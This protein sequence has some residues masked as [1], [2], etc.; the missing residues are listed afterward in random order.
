MSAAPRRSRVMIRGAV[1]GVG[2][3]AWVEYTALLRGLE[4]WVRNQ[5]D[6]SVEAVF[7]GSREDVK[8]MIELC[9]RGP[10]GAG[11][12]SVQEE[13]ALPNVLESRY[14]GEAFS[15]LPTQ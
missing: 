10:P 5:K 4:G 13:D 1:Q 3:R 14:P 2:Y 8:A 12:E 6:G 15:V 11:V 7:V 9:R